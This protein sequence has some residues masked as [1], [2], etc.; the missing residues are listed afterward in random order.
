M[1]SACT[2]VFEP[3]GFAGTQKPTFGAPGRG[4]PE[5]AFR[6]PVFRRPS[7][8]C[9]TLV[10]P[11]PSTEPLSPLMS[12]RRPSRERAAGVV[13]ASFG[14]ARRPHRHPV[15]DS[16]QFLVPRPSRSGGRACCTAPGA[17]TPALPSRRRPL[18]RVAR[19]HH[20]ARQRRWGLPCT[21]PLVAPRPALLR[22]R[23]S[24]GT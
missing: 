5:S 12:P 10:E 17:G 21:V 1:I 11:A 9:Q 7:H 14:A 16:S 13:P 19:L 23:S 3:Q 6:R 20:R 2:P 15:A 4:A 8:P 18:R 24:G 22:R